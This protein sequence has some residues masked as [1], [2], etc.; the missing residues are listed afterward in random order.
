M[1]YFRSHNVNGST[2]RKTTF[3]THALLPKPMQNIVVYLVKLEY[4]YVAPA[5]CF[6]RLINKTTFG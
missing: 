5:F 4:I 6:C 3:S 1:L 2:F